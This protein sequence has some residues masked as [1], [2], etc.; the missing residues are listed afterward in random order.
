[1]MVQLFVFNSA[2]R[3]AFAVRRQA[4]TARA[5]AAAGVAALGPAELQQ[6]LHAKAA[7]LKRQL[8]N[9]IVG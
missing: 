6:K 7:R 9:S 8:M 2:M 3:W 5:A 1:M 4:A